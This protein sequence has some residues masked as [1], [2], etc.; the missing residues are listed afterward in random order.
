MTLILDYNYG[1]DIFTTCLLLNYSMNIKK[2]EN[3]SYYI[4]YTSV[5][6]YMECMY[7]CIKVR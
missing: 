3:I 4:P 1:I 5:T 6:M 7:V 2:K